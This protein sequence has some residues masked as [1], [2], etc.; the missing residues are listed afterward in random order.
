MKIVTNILAVIGAIAVI[1]AVYK[2]FSKKAEEVPAS[3]EW[4]NKQPE[5]SENNF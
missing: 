4:A 5:E 3:E 1:N 2:K